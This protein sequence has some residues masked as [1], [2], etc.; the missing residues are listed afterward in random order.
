MWAQVLSLGEQQRLAFGRIFLQ[1]PA[2]VFMDEA[3]SAVDEPAEG[4]LYRSADRAPAPDGHRRA[5][6]IARASSPFMI[7]G[8]FSAAAGTGRLR[9]FLPL[10]QTAARGK[11]PR[12]ES[13]FDGTAAKSRVPCRP[14]DR[15]RRLIPCRSGRRQ[16]RARPSK[17]A[18]P[19]GPARGRIPPSSGGPGTSSTRSTWTA[20]P[21]R[22]ARSPSAPLPGW[23]TLWEIP[24]TARISPPAWWTRSAQ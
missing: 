10:R 12:S 22:L 1:R 21:S 5:S 14:G 15:C 4:T 16:D 18:R 24:A 17:G 3:T 13:A 6:A 9:G 7:R 2:W 19:G 20:L 8:S 11:P 23:S